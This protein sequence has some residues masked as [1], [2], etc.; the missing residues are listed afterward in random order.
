ME[1]KH[2]WIC[3]IIMKVLTKNAKEYGTFEPKIT[4]DTENNA[5]KLTEPQS[6]QEIDLQFKTLSEIDLYLG[7]IEILRRNGNFA[8]I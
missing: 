2:Y 1:I 8:K 5:I 3:K 7:Q 6:E 4:L